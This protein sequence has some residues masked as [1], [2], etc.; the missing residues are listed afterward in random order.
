MNAEKQFL[1]INATAYVTGLPVSYIRR[2]VRNGS[3]PHIKS[4]VKYLID[5]GEF[6]NTLNVASRVVRE[7]G[8]K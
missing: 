5:I 6:I 1:P 2:G 8:N 3:I 7:G 4:G